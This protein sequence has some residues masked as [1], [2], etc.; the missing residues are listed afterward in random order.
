MVSVSP[1]SLGNSPKNLA[2]QKAGSKKSNSTSETMDSADQRAS[3]KH[4]VGSA[5]ETRMSSKCSAA[6]SCQWREASQ[7][8]I[9]FDWDDT[10]CPSSWLRANSPPLSYFH[11]PPQEERYLKPLHELE[12]AVIEV[13]QLAQRY[14]KVVIITSA[15]HNWV[16]TSCTNFLPRVL[17]YLSNI[18]I[19]YAQSLW[20]VWEH[21]QR[22]RKGKP[23]VKEG[24]D[25]ATRTGFMGY[26]ISYINRI[27]TM[28]EKI[29]DSISD[30]T[31]HAG[32]RWKKL[33]F[34]T[35]LSAFYSRTV[36]QSWKNVI[37]VGD[38]DDERAATH[39]T[40][41]CCS[42]GRR[43]KRAKTIKMWDA[44]TIEELLEQV[45]NITSA[46][47]ALIMYDNNFEVEIDDTYA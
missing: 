25:D 19:V 21:E 39:Y 17:P 33:A 23:E 15:S 40:V 7:T 36:T 2:E 34:A 28:G 18:P 16:N 29:R 41:G 14:G 13:L 26:P 8:I 5:Y 31:E 38:A 1:C 3:S 32:Y 46:L 6:S 20:K 24:P 10:L 27:Y 45:K 30:T 37:S 9:V 11:P 22:L 12:D 35:E 42:P 4:S 44:P 47:P 43:R